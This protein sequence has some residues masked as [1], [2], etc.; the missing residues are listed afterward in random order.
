MSRFP[1]VNQLCTWLIHVTAF[2]YTSP[3]TRSS[4]AVG[5]SWTTSSIDLTSEKTTTWLG[6]SPFPSDFSETVILQSTRWVAI[7]SVLYVEPL[8][9]H[10]PQSPVD[11]AAQRPVSADLAM[12]EAATFHLTKVSP[13]LFSL[14]LYPQECR[15]YLSSVNSIGI[16][17]QK[18]NCLI[19]SIVS[20]LLL[21]HSISGFYCFL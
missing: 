14:H 11:L 7:P 5:Q 18:T 2:L 13:S 12:V 10:S 21:E 4:A 9:L 19:S 15:R 16:S 17:C 8:R 20:H 6:H 1:L 3:R